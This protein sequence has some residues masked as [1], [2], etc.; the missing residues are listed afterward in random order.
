MHSDHCNAGHRNVH[1][2]FIMQIRNFTAR[3]FICFFKRACEV[4]QKFI[5]SIAVTYAH[6]AACL[7]NTHAPSYKAITEGCV[8]L[9]LPKYI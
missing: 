7:S 3:I 2:T 5:T 9:R 4:F 1:I 6:A 8:N